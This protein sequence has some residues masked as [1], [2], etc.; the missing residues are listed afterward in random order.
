ME[1][2]LWGKKMSENCAW[3]RV[4]RLYSL[5]QNRGCR[6]PSPPWGGGMQ[7]EAGVPERPLDKAHLCALSREPCWGSGARLGTAGASQA[8]GGLGLR[9]SGR[10]H[11]CIRQLP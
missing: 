3:D 2:L 10:G 11:H 9:K 6:R 1:K 8:A 5:G 7:V 4:T